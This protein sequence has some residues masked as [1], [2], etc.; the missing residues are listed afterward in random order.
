MTRPRSMIKIKAVNKV[1][2]CLGVGWNW[3][4]NSLFIA[5]FLLSGLAPLGGVCV[6]TFKIPFTFFVKQGGL[7][8]SKYQKELI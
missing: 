7:L 8:A 4:A 6:H 3:E 1:D 2:L 5:V